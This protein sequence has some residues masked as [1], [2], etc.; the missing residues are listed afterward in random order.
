MWVR[1]GGE[2]PALPAAVGEARRGGFDL[3]LDFS[4]TYPGFGPNVLDRCCDA[5]GQ[6]VPGP[7]G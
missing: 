3:G 2:R 1:G 7:V 5:L 4:R 6:G